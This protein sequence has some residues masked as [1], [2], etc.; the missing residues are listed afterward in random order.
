LQHSI[1]T[2]RIEL[3]LRLYP[4]QSP[5][6]TLQPPFSLFAGTG[7]S[8]TIHI[9]RDFEGAMEFSGPIKQI[10]SGGELQRQNRLKCVFAIA[11]RYQFKDLAIAAMKESIRHPFP[12]PYVVELG[13]VPI[14]AYHQYVTYRF[15]CADIIAKLV[16]INSTWDNVWGHFPRISSSCTCRTV[17][18]GGRTFTNWALHYALK[19]GQS[20]AV[21]P[22]PEAVAEPKWFPE[23]IKVMNCSSCACDG[24]DRL[25]RFVNTFLVAEIQL[26]ISQVNTP[27]NSGLWIWI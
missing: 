5:Y 2:N 19:V 9:P 14:S 15:L 1:G 12:G 4:T 23:V 27:Y 18:I 26:A 11:Y 13:R 8:V 25:S 6:R 21:T 3:C 24:Y 16:E 10:S 20:L 17:S 7:N 22:C